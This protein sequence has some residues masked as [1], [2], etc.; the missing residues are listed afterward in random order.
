MKKQKK[1]LRIILFCVIFIAVG[2]SLFIAKVFWDK[3]ALP[4]GTAGENAEEDMLADA[5]NSESIADEDTP[6]ESEGLRSGYTLK[7][8]AEGMEYEEA[9]DLYEGE[10]YSILIPSE[11]W[12]MNGPDS[13]KSDANEKVQ[14]GIVCYAN[15]TLKQ[16]REE[17]EAAGYITDP[18]NKLYRRKVADG[19]LM[20][21]TLV[22]DGADV[23]G[24]MYSYPDDFEI[25]EGF[26]SRI[27]VIAASFKTSRNTDVD[28]EE[29]ISKVKELVASQEE[30]AAAIELSME[31]DTLTQADLNEK[32]Y[33]L[34]EAWDYALNSVW[35][36]LRNTLE[37]DKMQQLILEEREWIAMKEQAI[38]DAGAEFEG[39]SIK[40]LVMN[41]EAAKWTKI[42][43]YELLEL[44]G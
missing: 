16:V 10:G 18:D 29:A 26:G 14:I 22:A 28:R 35:D 32:S 42:R 44:L 5:E 8:M 15:T 21:R 33:K 11:G 4:E 41:M 36:V 2:L 27:P 34:Y 38:K 9:A 3:E 40:P 23:W 12:S 1:F 13:W 37:E 24:I 31:K 7:F 19:Y 30:Y 43:V 20:F 25:A 17:I 6:L 39:G